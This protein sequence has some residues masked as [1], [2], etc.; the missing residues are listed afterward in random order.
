MPQATAVPS[1]RARSPNSVSSKWWTQWARI[2]QEEHQAQSPDGAGLTLAGSCTFQEHRYGQRIRGQ[3]DRSPRNDS[4]CAVR[5]CG[6]ASTSH[7]A[8]TMITVA[9]RQ[10]R[11]SGLL[12][13][14][15]SHRGGWQMSSII[16][17]ESG[18]LPMPAVLGA[19]LPG[20][21]TGRPLNCTGQGGRPERPAHHEPLVQPGSLRSS[22]AGCR[23]AG[24]ISPSA[25]D[26]SCGCLG[27][28]SFRT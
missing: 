14:P 2:Y 8:V 11:S 4:R 10:G 17:F 3:G 19:Q 7:R 13:P 23:I 28:K 21:C 18:T 26:A 15:E 16:T 1:S 12:A 20:L 9:V 6:A 25:P 24:A 22:G 5:V 27:P